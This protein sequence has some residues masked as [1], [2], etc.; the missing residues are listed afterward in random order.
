MGWQ[1]YESDITR[2]K[3]TSEVERAKGN[4]EMANFLYSNALK[5]EEIFAML[6]S[7]RE[8]LLRHIKLE[9]KNRCFHCGAYAVVWDSDYSFED[10]FR[11]GEGIIHALHCTNCGADIT[12]G[13][14]LPEDK[15]QKEVVEEVTE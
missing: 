11:E 9:E 15:E 1:D 10:Y 12:Y 2:M 3:C 4:H 13:I 5:M 6:K 7:S 8:E 14:P